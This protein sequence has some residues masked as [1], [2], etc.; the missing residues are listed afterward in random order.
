MAKKQQA[1]AATSKPRGRKMSPDAFVKQGIEKLR[2][3]KD[4]GIHVV[5][6]GFN[7]AFRQYFNGEDPRPHLDR[8]AAEGVIT[9]RPARG[10]ATIALGDGKPHISSSA[11]LDKILAR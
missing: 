11:V 8:L 5:Y 10:G 6:S 9:V 2:Q 3:G 4:Q 7:Q 1:T